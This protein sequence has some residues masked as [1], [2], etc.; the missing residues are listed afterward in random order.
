MMNFCPKFSESSKHFHEFSRIFQ[1]KNISEIRLGNLDSY[2]ENCGNFGKCF[3]IFRKIQDE[4]Y[5][6]IRFVRHVKN[7]ALLGQM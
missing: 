7:L 6:S 3:R 1:K 2:M 4:G 5:S